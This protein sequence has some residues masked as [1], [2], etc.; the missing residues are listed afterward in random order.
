MVLFISRYP[1]R[2]NR[3]VRVYAF[4]YPLFF[5]SNSFGA[6]MFTLFDLQFGAVVNSAM[7]ILSVGST[8]AFL[9]LL[10]S[11]GEAVPPLHS[12]VTSQQAKALLSQLDA[13][14]TTLM[15]VSRR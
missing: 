9:L 14:N 12:K 3:N 4:V 2:L 10:N 8:L 1:I 7:T 13:L 11:A 6:L 5:L 15:R